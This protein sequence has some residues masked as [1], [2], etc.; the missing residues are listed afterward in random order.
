[1]TPRGLK[2]DR[3]NVILLTIDALRYDRL[4]EDMPFLK[5]LG[6]EPFLYECLQPRC[7]Y[8]LASCFAPNGKLPSRLIMGRDQTPVPSETLLPEVLQRNGWTT[9]LFAN[10]T[11]F[12]VRGLSQGFRRGDKDYA[13]SHYSVHG[14][15]PASQHLTDSMLKRLI[16]RVKKQ[17]KK[18]PIFY[19]DITM[20][21]TTRISMFP[22]FRV[23]YDDFD[24]Y[25]AICASVDHALEQFVDGL[26]KRQLWEN[27]ILIV[28]ADHGEEF[29]EHG[30]RFHGKSVYEEMTRVPLLIRFLCIRAPS[31]MYPLGR[32]TSRRRC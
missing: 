21:R 5:R 13:T 29:G 3:P 9:H 32:S 10:V 30:G 11:V 14:A 27:T 18:Q 6:G 31:G 26:K 28:T 4:L 22:V 7:I 24:R 8:L 16:V 2:G 12:F 19:G 15:K 1:M 20:T 17:R 25:R 23:K